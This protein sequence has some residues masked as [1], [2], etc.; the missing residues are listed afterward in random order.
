MRIGLT[1]GIASGKSLVSRMLVELG[2]PVVD[3]DVVARQVVVPGEPAYKKIVD[4]FGADI[5]QAD[6]KIDRK[7]LGEIIF[8]NKLQRETLNK[9]V[10]PIVRETMQKEAQQYEQEGHS[11][12]VLDIPLL[13]EN[14]LFYLV[15]TVWL[16]FVSEQTQLARLMKRDGLTEVAARARM[17]AQCPLAQ[18]RERANVVIDNEGPREKTYAQVEQAL[19][20]I[21]KKT[22]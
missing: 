20:T 16:V 8:S 11:I 1:G 21:R 7:K 13:Y 18:K 6:E 2:I 14:K 22:D 17:T 9:I 15:D 3:A 19:A 4:A 12:V 10:H 5:L